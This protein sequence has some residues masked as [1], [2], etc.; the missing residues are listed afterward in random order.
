MIVV[1]LDRKWKTIRG[2]QYEEGQEITFPESD[3][4]T[5]E[6]IVELKIGA[7]IKDTRPPEKKEKKSED[8]KNLP[9]ITATELMKRKKDTRYIIQD[10]LVPKTVNML[11]SA[12]G[13]YKSLLTLD[14]C[15]SV[16]LGEPWLGMPTTKGKVL[17]LDREN[18]ESELRN[19]LVS[20]VNGHGWKRKRSIMNVNLLI[21]FGTFDDSKF[22]AL[23][24]DHVNTEKISLIVVDTIRRFGN[25]QENSSDDIN[26]LYSAFQKIINGTKA[27][28]L[29]LHHANKE[30]GSYRGSVDLLGQVDTC[31]RLTKGKNEEFHLACEKS[32]S[33]EINQIDGTI[34]WQKEKEITHITRQDIQNIEQNDKYEKF[35][36]VRAW[37]LTTIHK[38]CPMVSD[39]FK[40]ADAL[41]EMQAANIDLPVNEQMSRA[42]LD[43]VMR[44]MCQRH[45]LSQTG[46][47]GEYRRLFS[48]DGGV[49]VPQESKD[50]V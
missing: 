39:T 47:K 16:A 17:I 6:K 48:L 26:K 18:N 21:Q 8:K 32:R 2:K 46:K 45:Y 37:A 5:A 9:T 27:S 1:R 28:I 12:P 7:I 33:G 44:N 35:R 30:G 14:A 38:L 49:I 43:R 20:L 36:K 40:R 24:A 4:S 23:L 10:F 22:L 11:Y 25:F 50:G 15:L 13:S 41:K 29:F 42:M 31:Y 3:R 34:E 19:R